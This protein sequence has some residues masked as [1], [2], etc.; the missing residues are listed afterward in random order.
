MAWPSDFPVPGSKLIS[1]FRPDFND[2]IN[3][4]VQVFVGGSEPAVT[5]ACMLW[6]DTGQGKFKQRNVANTGWVI[7]GDLEVDYGGCLPKSGG[8]MTGA[9]VMGGN[10]I[11]GLPAGSGDAPARYTDLAAY[12]RADGT[13]P[14]SAFPTLPAGNPTV[15][16]HAAPKGYVD[17]KVLAGGTYTG[18]IV[19]TVAPSVDQH[20]MRKVDVSNLI[21]SH[22]HS[23]VA[24]QGSKIPG[25][26]ISSVG[27]PA[28]WVLQADGS[29]GAAFVRVDGSFFFMGNEPILIGSY[30][31]SASW[32]EVDLSLLVSNDC[33]AVMVMP[34]AAGGSKWT[35]AFRAWN[36]AA[37]TGYPHYG[38][39]IASAHSYYPV[40]IPVNQRKIEMKATRIIGSGGLNLWKWTEIKA[41]NNT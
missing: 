17:S 33:H 3:S 12:V 14:F 4:L 11:T 15:S 41:I 16:T 35:L 29:N 10:A 30:P 38:L 2:I 37:D 25:A 21:D 19:M 27:A 6:A 28:K 26:N 7:R 34:V 20:V 5:Y 8:T 31:S 32:Q 13:I 39:G 22:T 1:A 36:S 24:G 40:P 9:I 23:G 18:Q